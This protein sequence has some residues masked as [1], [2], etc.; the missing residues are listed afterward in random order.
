[1]KRINDWLHHNYSA[2][3][4]WVNLGAIA[5]A[6]YAGVTAYDSGQQ[7]NRD[8]VH[9]T[10]LSAALV[11]ACQYINTQSVEENNSRLADFH[12]DGFV[13]ARFLVPTPTETPAQKVIT[14][15]FG[16]ALKKAVASKS[17]SPLTNCSTAANGRFVVPPAIPF[18][19]ELPPPAALGH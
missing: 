16:S 9:Q 7:S 14:S 6:V 18:S 2:I 1:M 19:K 17:W 5:I 4:R 3:S 8:A 10:Q 15:E 11:S 13:A 12:V